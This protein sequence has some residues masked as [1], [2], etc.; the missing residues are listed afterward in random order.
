MPQNPDVPSYTSTNAGILRGEEHSRFVSSP[1]L[2]SAI[3]VP[4]YALSSLSLPRL[5]MQGVTEER[6]I[7][8]RHNPIQRF[9]SHLE[10]IY[11][12]NGATADPNPFVDVN[13]QGLAVEMLNLQRY[14][15]QSALELAASIPKKEREPCFEEQVFKVLSRNLFKANEDVGPITIPFGF[16]RETPVENGVV[17]PEALSWIVTQLGIPNGV[18]NL[19]AT[20]DERHSAYRTFLSR[21]RRS[22][23][24]DNF[25][26]PIKWPTTIKDI[27]LLYSSPYVGQGAFA[28]D[29]EAIKRAT[30]APQ[31]SM[32]ENNRTYGASLQRWEQ[33]N[34]RAYRD[35][36]KPAPPDAHADYID[37]IT[38]LLAWS[39]KDP[40]A[41]MQAAATVGLDSKLAGILAGKDTI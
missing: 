11:Q 2:L 31:V 25:P 27:S 9:L 34:P 24:Q 23:R 21:M 14:W 32:Y 5:E 18:Q 28:L 35:C 8:R 20:Q 38:E 12:A 41:A 36:F 13:I 19:N 16:Y 4:D 29:P 33:V 15:Q 17:Y 22:G 30:F 40:Q 37:A 39:H 10:A 7:R 1:L 26:K 6:E 3:T